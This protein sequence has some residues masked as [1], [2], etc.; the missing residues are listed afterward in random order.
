MQHT[1]P[2]AVAIIYRPPNHSKFLVIFEENLPKLSTS[3]RDI[4]FLDDFNINL[5]DNGNVFQK[6][7]S[8]VQ[9]V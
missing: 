8:N 4:Y 1:R 7:S 5:F 2:I 9:L 3:Y 6:S